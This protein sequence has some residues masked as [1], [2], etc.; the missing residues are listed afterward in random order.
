MRAMW[1]SGSRKLLILPS[2]LFNWPGHFV[3]WLL[4]GILITTGNQLQAVGLA[5]C[6][7]T[8]TAALGLSLLVFRPGRTALWAAWLFSVMGTAV[9]LFTYREAL[10]RPDSTIFLVMGALGSI[11]TSWVL[12]GPGGTVA[13][14]AGATEGPTKD[15][16]A[17]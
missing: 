16:G 9:G 6:G 15:G 14:S 3:L 7:S 8:L 5:V 10:T 2:F 12:F 13:M 11:L 1:L 4:F 17:A